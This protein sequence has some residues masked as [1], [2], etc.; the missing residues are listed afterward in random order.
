MKRAAAYN[1]AQAG[2]SRIRTVLQWLV[3]LCFSFISGAQAVA[4]SPSEA[5]SSQSEGFSIDHPE[6]LDRLVHE[7][8][9][10]SL[11]ADTYVRGRYNTCDLHFELQRVETP[12]LSNLL[13]DSDVGSATVAIPL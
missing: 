6:H 13:I 3:L 2:S 1:S 7:A 10:F 11:Y 9:V 8:T 4:P 5:A 12:T